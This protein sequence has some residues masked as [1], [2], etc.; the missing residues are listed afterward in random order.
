MVRGMRVRDYAR[1][2]ATAAIVKQVWL[3]YFVAALALCV[4][5]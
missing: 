3:G 4:S 2:D 1:E 5:V